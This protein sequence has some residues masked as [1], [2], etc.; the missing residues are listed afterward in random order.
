MSDKLFDAHDF[1]THVQNDIQKGT[2]E[3]SGRRMIV[4]A[5]EGDM[6]RLETIAGEPAGLHPYAGFQLIEAGMSVWVEPVARLTTGHQSRVQSFVVI[7]PILEGSPIKRLTG[8]ALRLVNAM[9]LAGYQTTAGASLQWSL[10]GA[11][12][13][14]SFGAITGDSLNVSG[15]ITGGDLVVASIN[16]VIAFNDEQTGSDAGPTTD[17]TNYSNAMVTQLAL[18]VGNWDINV[19]ATLGL[20][21]SAAGRSNLRVQIDNNLGS[22]VSPNCPSASPNYRTAGAT[23]GKSNVS[24]NRTIDIEIEFKS[25]DAGT[26]TANNPAMFGTARRKS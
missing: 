18:P 25:L 14:A 17:T 24:G 19:F 5:V 7:G 15:D 26:T 12:G 4:T 1:W 20:I 22:A 11:T 6:I 23:Y 3:S 16:A 21:H 8:E 10:D 9:D 2:Y 13:D